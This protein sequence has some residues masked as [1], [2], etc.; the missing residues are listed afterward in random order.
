MVLLTRQEPSCQT[1]SGLVSADQLMKRTTAMRPA[2]VLVMS[3][4]TVMLLST[5]FQSNLLVTRVCVFGCVCAG[6]TVIA[7]AEC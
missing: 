5:T 2:A 1:L 7:G 3:P 6:S 4:V